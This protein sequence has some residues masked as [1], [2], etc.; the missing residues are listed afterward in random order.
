MPQRAVEFAVYEREP[1]VL[2]RHLL[3]LAIALDFELPRRE[4]AE[5]LLEVW[6]NALL[7]EKTATYLAAKARELSLVFTAEEGPLAPLFDLSAL[8]MKERD[9]LD[10]IFRSWAENVEFD[11]VRLRD[12]R[13]RSFYTTRYD[14]RRNVLDWDYQMELMPLSSIV[15]KLHFREWRMTGMGPFV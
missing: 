9:A 3:L 15:H 1:E 11:V 12:E 6:A 5:V 2:A 14:S 13:L 4:R 10:E 8:K 7:R